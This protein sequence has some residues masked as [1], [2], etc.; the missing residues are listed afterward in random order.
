MVSAQS[1]VVIIVS[2]LLPEK[3]RLGKGTISDFFKL[4]EDLELE[5]M[6]LVCLGCLCFSLSLFLKPCSVLAPQT[7]PLYSLAQPGDI[8]CLF[9]PVG[10]R[11]QNLT[12]L[13]LRDRSAYFTGQEMEDWRE[14]CLVQG[15]P[16]KQMPLVGVIVAYILAGMTK[17][18][19]N[20]REST[21]CFP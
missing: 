4:G 12:T 11:S 21:S 14:K 16:G 13:D 10:L 1:V 5:F 3:W 19:S 18:G 15:H 20:C 17:P 7:Q 2:P 8:R 9:P 6:P